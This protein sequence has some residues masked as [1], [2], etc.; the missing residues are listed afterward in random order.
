M[1]QENHGPSQ[2]EMN[3]NVFFTTQITSKG[4]MKQHN[5]GDE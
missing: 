3:N 1:K 4:N 2:C 5:Q